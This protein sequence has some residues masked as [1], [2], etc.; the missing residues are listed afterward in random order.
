[1]AFTAFEAAPEPTAFLANAVHVYSVPFVKPV[2]V[3]GGPSGISTVFVCDAL[4]QV[5]EPPV[6]AEPPSLGAVKFRVIEP[7]PAVAVRFV[8]AEGTVAGV[9][10]AA[11]DAGPAPSE[12][13]ARTTQLYSIPFV[14]PD[15]TIG[16]EAPDADTADP[17]EVGVQMAVKLVMVAPPLL[18]GAVNATEI[19]P[20]PR[21]S[22]SAVGAPGTVAVDPP[23][24]ELPPP[25]ACGV[26]D[27]AAEAGPLPTAFLATTV[28]E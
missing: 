1:M 8:I 11:V 6:I 13:V 27:A 4:A 3:T 12:F 17:D 22:T 24:P 5:A 28:H 26:P 14:K 16:L 25:D 19:D 23:P 18:D 7:S 2:K 21:V 20:L 10:F 15:T 9:A